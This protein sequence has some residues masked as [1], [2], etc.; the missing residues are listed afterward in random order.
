MLNRLPQ[1]RRGRRHSGGAFF[2]RFDAA[3]AGNQE[4]NDKVESERTP[5]YVLPLPYLW[6]LIDRVKARAN[7]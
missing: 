7:Y 6:A 3:V 4:R 5:R 1:R 2:E